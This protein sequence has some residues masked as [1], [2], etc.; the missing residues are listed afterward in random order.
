MAHGERLLRTVLSWLLVVAVEVPYRMLTVTD[1]DGE[2]QYEAIVERTEG[3]GGRLAISPR[4]NTRVFPS[5]GLADFCE[6]D[7]NAITGMLADVVVSDTIAAIS[8]VVG[9]LITAGIA[10]L[11]WS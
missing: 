4:I 6:A 10:K 8:A 1:R 5:G 2:E 11:Y 9:T 3:E 7:A